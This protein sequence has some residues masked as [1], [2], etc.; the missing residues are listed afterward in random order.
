MKMVGRPFSVAEL[1]R[2]MKASPYRD[3]STFCLA[4]IRLWRI[5]N[6]QQ[7]N[8]IRKARTCGLATRFTYE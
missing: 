6:Q 2:R 3:K 1:L 5:N 8:L 4:L 7:K